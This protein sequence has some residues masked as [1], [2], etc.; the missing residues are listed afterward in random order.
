M[1]QLRRIRI[2]VVKAQQYRTNYNLEPQTTFI[3]LQQEPTSQ[4]QGP[5]TLG[6][7]WYATDLNYSMMMGRYPKLKEEV[8]G[9]NTGCEI[10]S[11]PN[12]KLAKWPTTSC[13]LALACQ[14]SVSK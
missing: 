11:L 3:I 14:P 2:L 12:G 4:N 13:T 6:C 9:L 7:L 1:G 10:S 8:G 5:S